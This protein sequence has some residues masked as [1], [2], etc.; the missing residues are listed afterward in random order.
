[1]SLL[2]LVSG[3]IW[4]LI[5]YFSFF[6]WLCVGM[7]ILGLIWWRYKYPDI[8]RPVKVSFFLLRPVL[9]NGLPIEKSGN[10]QKEC[11]SVSFF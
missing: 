10:P 1:M 4:S 6:N 7:A 11:R 3:D 5:T 2:Y 8:E 9:L